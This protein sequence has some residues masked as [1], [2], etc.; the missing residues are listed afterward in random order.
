ML[1]DAVCQVTDCP[2]KF[3]GLPEDSL[4]PRRAIMLPDESFPSY[5]LDVFGRPQRHQRRASAS[6]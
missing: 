6:G 1:F 5:F 4:A 2:T 3:A